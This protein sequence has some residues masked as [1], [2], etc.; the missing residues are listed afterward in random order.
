[1]FSAPGPLIPVLFPVILT[2]KTVSS[3]IS[4]CSWRVVQPCWELVT[5]SNPVSHRGPEE[6][7]MY[8]RS[9]PPHLWNNSVS[10]LKMTENWFQEIAL[11]EIAF[12]YVNTDNHYEDIITMNIPLFFQLTSQFQT[13]LP[14]DFW[15]FLWSLLCAF[16]VAFHSFSS[17]CLT[18]DAV[19]LVLKCKSLQTVVEQIG[20]I[21]ARAVLNSIITNRLSMLELQ[22]KI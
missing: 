5:A 17:V 3:Y 1:M 22:I 13:D 8:S 18:V 11:L 19:I 2:T 7:K 16:S 12:S 6:D 15:H 9:P 21:I 14:C 20:I 4:K 10:V